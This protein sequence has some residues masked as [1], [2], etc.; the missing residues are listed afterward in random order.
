MPRRGRANRRIHVADNLLDFL[1]PRKHRVQRRR[2]ETIVC[3][4]FC[5]KRDVFG[6]LAKVL[7]CSERRERG[8]CR[9]RRGEKK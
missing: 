8:K 4:E 7:R 6:A 5:F 1:D 2:V 3:N 9:K